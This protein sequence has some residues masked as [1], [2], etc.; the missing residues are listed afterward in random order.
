M[1]KRW[2]AL[3]AFVF[4]VSVHQASAADLALKAAPSQAIA[5]AAAASWTGWYVGVEGGWAHGRFRQ[6]NQVSGVSEGWFNQDGGLVGGTLGYN[7]QAGT[8][9]Y[10]L[11]TD[12]A[13][14]DVRGTQACG[15]TLTNTCGTDI[16]AYGTVRGR[17]GAL[18]LSNT[19]LYATGGLAYAD[20]HAWK[21]NGVTT[22][23]NWRAGWTVGAGAEAMIL[24]RWSVKLEYLYSDFPGTA[25]TYLA[26]AATPVTAEERNVHMIRGGLNWHF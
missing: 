15:R 9:V 21:D 11:E 24:P 7:W 25:T 20:I 12:L 23:D 14:A 2:A 5:P 6:T 13:W 1:K 18:V 26:A 22:G 10:G 19:M 17:L 16:R 8:W 4:G 3:A